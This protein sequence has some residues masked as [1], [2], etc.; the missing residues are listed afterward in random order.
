[1][2]SNI[3]QTLDKG[4][5]LC[6]TT[7]LFNPPFTDPFIMKLDKCGELEWCKGLVY[8][9]T[10]DGGISVK[11]T[12]DGG[13]VMDAVFYGDDPNNRIRMIKFDGSGEL[14]WYKIYN[15]DSTMNS[16]FIEKM[17]SDQSN[18]LLSGFC[19]NPNWQRPYY[20][21]T[22]TAG[23]ETWRLIY[24][25][26]TGFGFVGNA[27]SST[28]DQHGNYYS[29]GTRENYPELLKFSGQG[30]ELMNVDLEPTANM[31]GASLIILLPTDT[32]CIIDAAWAVGSTI[33][34]AILK[35]DTLGNIIKTTYLPDPDNSSS[36]WATLTFDHKVLLNGIN[37]LNGSSR[38]VLSKFNSELNYDSVYTQHFTYDSLCPHQ[39][40]SDTI[41]PSCGA[42]GLQEPFSNPGSAT[43]KIYPNPSSN[44]IT[45]EF[46]KYVVV[47]TGQS[48]FGSTTVYYQWKST[49][50]EVSDLSG[51]EIFEKEIIHVQNILEMNVSGWQRGMY[52]FRLLYNNQIISG[53]KV[54]VE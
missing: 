53:V 26:H 51:K 28:R 45:I 31:G 24:S 47:K 20:I 2:P 13:Y 10:N 15:R 49:T 30:Y 6:G 8:D 43:L 25:Q 44:K 39:I 14:L 29:A 4:F 50:L 38:I 23:N 54:V 17:Y 37:T 42:L 1:M 16:E 35:T 12:A 3:E 22:D 21:Q 52:Y 18:F 7:T 27:W 9:N 19:Y 40:V 41:I 5:I 34:Y 36:M 46:P 11:P 33:Y 32:T 48:G